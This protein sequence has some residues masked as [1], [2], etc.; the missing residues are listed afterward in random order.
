MT[1]PLQGGGIEHPGGHVNLAAAL[2]LA[3]QTIL[4]IDMGP[5][6]NRD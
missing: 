3:D 4:L 5:Q 6:A 1:S 2:T